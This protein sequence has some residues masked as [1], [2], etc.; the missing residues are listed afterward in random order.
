[1]WVRIP[2]FFY[3]FGRGKTNFLGGG[4]GY[5]FKTGKPMTILAFTSMP[6]PFFGAK[7]E[8]HSEK[9]VAK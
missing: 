4:W 3:F 5:N 8:C 9:K 7:D 6:H 2:R 1:M